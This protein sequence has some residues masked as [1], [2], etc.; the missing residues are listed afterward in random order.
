MENVKERVNKCGRMGHFMKVNGVMTW[1]TVR[2]FSTSKMEDITKAI[3][4]TTNFMGMANSSQPIKIS[5]TKVNF[6]SISPME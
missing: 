6:S 4:R 1:Q 2:E 3:S 5:S